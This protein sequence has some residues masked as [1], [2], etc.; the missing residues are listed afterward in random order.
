[1]KSRGRDGLVID[2]GGKLCRH[3]MSSHVRRVPGRS[4]RD[5]HDGPDVLALVEYLRAHSEMPSGSAPALALLRPEGLVGVTLAGLC[6]VHDFPCRVEV[7]TDPYDALAW[8]GVA[9]ASHSISELDD[10]LRR[11]AEPDS[12]L[13]ALRAYLGQ[14]PRKTDLTTASAALGVSGRALQ[15]K[16]KQAHTSFRAEQ[17][18]A[19]IQRAKH[20]LRDTNYEIKRIAFEVGCSSLAAF[21]TLFRRIEGEAPSAWRSQT[22]PP[23]GPHFRGLSFQRRHIS[24]E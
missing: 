17:T 20:L 6:K 12:T 4:H 5:L 14:N 11:I 21:S 15:R 1:M 24:K 9:D 22:V 19:Q 8:L 16:L 7:F 23:D 18:A 2:S 10:V 13:S 3:E